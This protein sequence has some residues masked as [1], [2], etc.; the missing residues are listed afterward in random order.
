MTPSLMNEAYTMLCPK[1][2]RQT[3][4]LAPESMF[5]SSPSYNRMRK[6]KLGI[7]VGNIYAWRQ[8]HRKLGKSDL[9]R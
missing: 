3:S 2:K 9:V 7:R 1:A 6:A 4:S 8:T 5:N